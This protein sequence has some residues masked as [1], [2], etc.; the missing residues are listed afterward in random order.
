MAFHF[1]AGKAQTQAERRGKRD[2]PVTEITLSDG[3]IPSGAS[4]PNTLLVAIV[5][6]EAAT[7]HLPLA[8]V[9]LSTAGRALRHVGRIWTCYDQSSFAFA[10]RIVALLI[11]A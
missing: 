3:L 9:H 6:D 8:L 4:I 7:H 10:S 11:R 5:I 2:V 1:R